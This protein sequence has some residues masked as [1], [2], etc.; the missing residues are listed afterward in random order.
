MRNMALGHLAQ[1]FMDEATKRARERSHSLTS[2]TIRPN[3]EV[4]MAEKQC[5]ICEETK[6]PAAFNS[7]KKT[8][9]GCFSYCRLCQSDYN[10]ANWKRVRDR[11]RPL[12]SVRDRFVRYNI[13]ADQFEAMK[14][15]QGHCCAICNQPESSKFRGRVKQ[16]SVDH[17][18]KTGAIRAL[19]CFRCNTILGRVHDNPATLI[20]AAAYLKKHHATDKISH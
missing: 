4:I 15:E 2:P 3:D 11:R 8:R 6:P 16:L 9:D 13:T 10:K 20:K 14:A 19:L 1:E 17:D 7:S 18:H 5:S 12:K